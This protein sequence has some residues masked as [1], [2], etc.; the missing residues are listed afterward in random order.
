MSER[1]FRSMVTSEEGARRLRTVDDLRTGD[2]ACFIYN[3]EQDYEAVMVAFV[4]AG[5][6]ERQRVVFVHDSHSPEA[7]R[8]MLQRAEIDVDH[9]EFREQLK[10][11]S[12]R[13][14]FCRGAGNSV[15]RVL[16][17]LHAM[18]AM[19]LADGWSALR[20]TTEM[21]WVLR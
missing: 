11:V 21:T 20:M 3:D 2:D 12:A 10:F 17:Q 9:A 13:Q 15:E 14:L 5:L 8:A 16:D 19:A 6:Q 4:R 7:V 18:T 1:Q